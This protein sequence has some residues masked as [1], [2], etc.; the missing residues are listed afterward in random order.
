MQHTATDRSK[1]FD[2]ADTAA[3]EAWIA[4]LPKYV[5]PQVQRA[6]GVIDG[7]PVVMLQV[8]WNEAPS[9]SRGDW[10]G[11]P[12]SDYAKDRLFAN[13]PL[14][15]QSDLQ[16]GD[17]FVMDPSATVKDILTVTEV[18]A[19]GTPRVDNRTGRIPGYSKVYLLREGSLREAVR[20]RIA[21]L[22]QQE[23]PSMGRMAALTMADDT[24][25]LHPSLVQES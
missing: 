11:Q 20:N 2:A 1:V 4:R 13:L 7:R 8:D 25:R 22:A 15:D 10:Y 3:Q 9:G 12:T 14:V 17:R 5:Q 23:V 19:W 6:D 24:I 16:V 21:D 18:D